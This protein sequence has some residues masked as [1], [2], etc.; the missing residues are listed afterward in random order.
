LTVVRIVQRLASGD[1]GLRDG[2][3]A[4]RGGAQRCC[5]RRGSAGGK[6]AVVAGASADWREESALL[7]IALGE[8]DEECDD[9]LGFD[10][11]GRIGGDLELSS[12]SANGAEA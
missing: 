3:D 8:D 12:G 10:E 2:R 5:G 6:Y 1:G 4:T 11:L 9:E 7:A